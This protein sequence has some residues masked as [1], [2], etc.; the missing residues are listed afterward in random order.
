MI[1]M[2]N[3]RHFELRQIRIVM[4][5]GLYLIMGQKQNKFIIVGHLAKMREKGY[6][7]SIN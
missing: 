2:N 6:V 7:L 3:I 4:I 1:L 5:G